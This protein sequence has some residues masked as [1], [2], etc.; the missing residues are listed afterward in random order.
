MISNAHRT[1]YSSSAAYLHTTLSSS[2]MHPRLTFT[3]NLSTRT[4]PRNFE[5]SKPHA[6]YRSQLTCGNV[7]KGSRLA[8]HT[9]SKAYLA[10]HDRFQVLPG[11]S[12]IMWPGMNVG[13][14]GSITG[15]GTC[16]LFGKCHQR[17]GQLI[18]ALMYGLRRCRQLDP[19]DHGQALRD[20]SRSHP[21]W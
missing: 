5:I 9:Q 13:M 3:P 16:S 2:V 18:V 4:Q 21:D 17:G 12:D 1:D 6:R 15:T 19:Q 20:R 8:A 11:F 7:G 14:T 10:K